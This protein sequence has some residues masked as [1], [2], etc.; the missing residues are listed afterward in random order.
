MSASVY[1]SSDVRITNYPSLM[2]Y[3]QNLYKL[4]YLLTV[5][6]SNKLFITSSK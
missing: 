3:L 1:E 4:I 5:I 6:T 2:S